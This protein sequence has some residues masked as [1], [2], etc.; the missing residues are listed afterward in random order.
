G[1]LRSQDQ[2]E[3]EIIRPLGDPR[4]H[5]AI[6]CAAR[7]CPPLVQEA[8]VADRLDEQLDG[9]VR[10]FMADPAHYRLDG[11]SLTVNKVLDWF[12]DDFGGPEGLKAFFAGYATGD[13][14]TVLT[15]PETTVSYF[16]YDWTLNDIP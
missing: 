7:S 8:Y 16:D 2:I 15:D 5:F 11:R 14:A 1:V 4:I 10:A 9:R 6:N 13:A 12:G 3:H